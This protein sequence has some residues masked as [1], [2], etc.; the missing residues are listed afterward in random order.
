VKMPFAVDCIV[1]LVRR[2]YGIF[3]RCGLDC[4]GYIPV[5]VGLDGLALHCW[6]FGKACI[7]TP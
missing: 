7:D 2:R 5:L 6:S 3:W 4:G 1:L